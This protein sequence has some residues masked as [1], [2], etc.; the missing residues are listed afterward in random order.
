MNIKKYV[1]G[2]VVSLGLTSS[3]FADQILIHDFDTGDKPSENAYD[4][5]AWNKDP[6]DTTQGCVESF[7]AVDRFGDKGMS[8]R[9]DYD[10]DSP[11]PAY[12]GMWMKVKELDLSPYKYLNFYIK[13]N[14]EKGFSKVIKLELK[15]DTEAGKYLFTQ[16]TEEWTLAKIPLSEFR[17]VRDWTKMKEFVIV[18]DDLNSRP[19]AGTIYVDNIFFSTE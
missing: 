6:N 10:V 13:G 1:A 17:G 14:K 15:N 3:S 5:G 19:K 11:A 2:L 12:N 7:D 9:L 16:V 8:L 4:F 18:F